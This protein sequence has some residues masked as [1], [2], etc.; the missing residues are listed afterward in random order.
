MYLLPGNVVVL[1][2]MKSLR[3]PTH[4]PEAFLMSFVVPL[5]KV[6]P[7]RSALCLSLRSVVVLVVVF[8]V[9]VVVVFLAGGTA[10]RRR[11][12]AGDGD[13]QGEDPEAVF[14]SSESSCL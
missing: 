13:R 5:R 2:L 4:D 3:S 1:C 12:T 9:V 6:V 10:R 7:F 11:F 14:P 8:V